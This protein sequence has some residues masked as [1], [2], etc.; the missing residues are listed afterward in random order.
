MKTGV[1][2]RIGKVGQLAP[3][4]GCRIERAHICAG[5]K[6]PPITIIEP[7]A[8]AENSERGDRHV[9]FMHPGWG[10]GRCGRGAESAGLAR[11][12]RLVNGMWQP[13]LGRSWRVGTMV[14]VL[15]ALQ[16]HMPTA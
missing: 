11:K 10:C 13:S 8:T 12:A 7:I 3:V 15:M 5:T 9:S 14:P 1:I 6:P 16:G 2:G 4:S